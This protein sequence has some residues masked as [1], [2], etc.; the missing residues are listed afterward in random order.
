MIKGLLLLICSLVPYAEDNTLVDNVTTIEVN[1]FYDEHAKRIFDQ[2]VYWDNMKFSI[3]D[4]PQIYEVYGVVAWK[5]IKGDS[6]NTGEI[7]IKHKNGLYYAEWY[8]I[9]NYRFVKH[10]VI[11]NQFR[12][13]WTQEDPELVNREVIPKEKRRKLKEWH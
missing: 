4:Y 9:S 12:R 8:T 10:I 5:L 7:S 3:S 6:F 2:I 13:T 1:T 11:A